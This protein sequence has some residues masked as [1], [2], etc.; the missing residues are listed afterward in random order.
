M[1]DAEA[2]R[3]WEE[4]AEVWTNLSRQGWDIF[5]DHFNTPAFLDLLP[6]VSGRRGLDLG[7]GEGHNTRLLA[8]RC[9]AMYGIDIAPTFLKHAREAGG[10]IHYAAASAQSLP[11]ADGAFDFVTALMSL[12]DMPE[13]ERVLAE[14]HR[15]LKPGGFLQF[16]ITHPCFDTEHRRRVKDAAGRT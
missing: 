14:A 5:R 4:N 8:Q 1:R 16:S 6:E 3:Y 9:A 10:G 7:S 2:G 13:P 11:F 12:M 15:V